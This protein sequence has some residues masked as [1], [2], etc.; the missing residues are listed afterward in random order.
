VHN[1]VPRAGPQ[2]LFEKRCCLIAR[3]L[4]KQIGGVGGQRERGGCRNFSKAGGKK[5]HMSS[6]T[7]EREEKKKKKKKE[8]LP[9]FKKLPCSAGDSNT[10][11]W[12]RNYHKRCQQ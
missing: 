12:R 2:I 8:I 1:K 10:G 3:R 5:A 11:Y 6:T 7:E 4:Q 9:P